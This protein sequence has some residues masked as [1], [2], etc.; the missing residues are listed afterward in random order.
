VD[1]AVPARS[2]PAREALAGLG[3]VEVDELNL[4]DL[5][6]RPRLRGAR[7]GYDVRP[8]AVDP[9]D[10]EYLWDVPEELTGVNASRS[11]SEP[12]TAQAPAV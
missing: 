6:K 7:A 8:D 5:N 4:A 2:D 10:A 3:S 9:A 1:V 12:G 11:P